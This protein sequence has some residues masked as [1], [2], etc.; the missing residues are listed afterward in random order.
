MPTKLKLLAAG[1]GAAG[2]A[3]LLA[4]PAGAQDPPPPIAVEVV[5]QRATFTDDV[6]LQIKNKLDGQATRV[7]NLSDPSRVATARITVQPGAR[8]PWHTHPGPVTV[9]VVEGQ[10]TYVQATDCVPRGY[11]AGSIFIDPGQGNVHTAFNPTGEVTVLY[12]TFYDLP[13]E[14]PLTIP[15]AGPADC[16][17]TA[18]THSH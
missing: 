18:G 7:M 17:V 1:A 12:A 14:G 8:F 9:N 5:T 10:L 4:V 16:E 11:P 2:L 13:A 6:R 15:V 3:A